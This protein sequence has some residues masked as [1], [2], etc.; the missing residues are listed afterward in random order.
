VTLVTEK[1]QLQDIISFYRIV[2]HNFGG[3]GGCLLDKRDETKFIEKTKSLKGN[4]LRG[5]H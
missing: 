2:P 3:S 5:T 4:I 1:D